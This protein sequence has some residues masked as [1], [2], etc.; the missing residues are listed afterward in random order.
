MPVRRQRGLSIVELLIGLALGLFIVATATTL[1]LG[2]LQGHRELLLQSRLMQDL[3]VAAD[4]VTR[5]LRRAG[6][7]GE[8][9][10]AV[11]PS[12]ASGA[13]SNPYTL[14]SPADHASDAVTFRFSRDEHEDH[15]VDANEHFGFR[16]QHGVIEMLL[17]GRWQALTDSATLIVTTF[18]ITPGL[19][20]IA[21]DGFCAEPCAPASTVCPPR[22]LVRSL[23][24]S[25]SGRA[26]TDPAMVR[27]VRS[28]VRLRNDTIVG[29]CTD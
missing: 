26:A 14:L 29:R 21:L 28:H 15:G 8:A 23:A 5:D 6:Y 27:T 25:I 9:S 12:A 18:R 4:V 1:L 13:R 11:R 17:G 20:E 16:L 3:R 7:W 19:Q 2:R 22:Q 10:A 24:V